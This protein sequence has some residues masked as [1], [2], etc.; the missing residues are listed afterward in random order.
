MH[1]NVAT[2]GEAENL[3][4]RVGIT[5][6]HIV[7]STKKSMISEILAERAKQVGGSTHC[8]NCGHCTSTL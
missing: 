4:K 2:Q 7:M 3:S 8:S 6:K 1:K 5:L